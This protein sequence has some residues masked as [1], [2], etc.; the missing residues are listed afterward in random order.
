MLVGHG[1]RQ[2]LSWAHDLWVATEN[3][4]CWIY[5]EN[6]DPSRIHPP[7]DL[8]TGLHTIFHF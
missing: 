6:S 8:E 5:I 2:T 1:F 7:P 4:I 3:K